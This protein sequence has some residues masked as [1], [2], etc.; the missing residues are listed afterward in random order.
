M[1]DFLF[2]WYNLV[3]EY[4]YEYGH[5]NSKIRIFAYNS[6]IRIISYGKNPLAH[7]ADYQSFG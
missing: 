5:T 2:F 3:Y 1:A 7:S 6:Y 4:R